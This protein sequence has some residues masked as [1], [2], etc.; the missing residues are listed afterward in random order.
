MQVVLRALKNCIIWSTK[1]M[2][3]CSFSA[4]NL[5]PLF[6]PQRL[7]SNAYVQLPQETHF[8]DFVAGLTL[9]TRLGYFELASCL[10]AFRSYDANRWPCIKGLELVQLSRFAFL[11]GLLYRGRMFWIWSIYCI[12]LEGE[13]KSFLERDMT[14]FL[15]ILS[16]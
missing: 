11:V 15:R 14:R 5:A 12:Q 13:V 9:S 6:H 10:E 3:F 8:D 2:V 4:Q 7:T 1:E 16:M